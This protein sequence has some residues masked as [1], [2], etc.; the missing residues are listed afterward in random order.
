MSTPGGWRPPELEEQVIERWDFD[1]LDASERAFA[2]AAASMGSTTAAGL[3][4]RTQQARALGLQQRV[5]TA[6][7]ALD[8]VEADLRTSGGTLG[9]LGHVRARLEI[10]RGRLLNSAGSPAEARPHFETAY[11]EAT[12][13]GLE[14]LAVDALH[15]SA[16]VAGRLE[17][18]AAAAV[19]N[20]KAISVAEESSDLAARRWL[21]SLLNN[22]AWARHDGGSYE[23]A[24]DLF[25]RAVEV[26]IEQGSIREVEIAEWCVGRCL[27]SLERYA[28]ALRIQERLLT[29][30]SGAQD[31]YVHEEIGENLLA[32]DR[33]EEAAGYF[34]SAYELLA[35]DDWLVE[36]ETERLE[37][38]RSL[39]GS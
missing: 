23:D 33:A 32:L 24:L 15:M 12:A 6:S 30:A 21:G 18:P 8:A 37:R 17:G 36:H 4:F 25:R 16:I 7:A 27:R 29:S 26:R 13:A 3:V 34:T 2:A 11:R 22:L 20:A 31:G 28:E 38:L 14:G 9:E 19:L 10:E 35:G 1:D 5:E 39:S